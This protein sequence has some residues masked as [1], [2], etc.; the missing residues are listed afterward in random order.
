MPGEADRRLAR[1]AAVALLDA[2]ASLRQHP[3]NTSLH[4]AVLR[5]AYAALQAA[6]IHAPLVLGLLPT[7]DDDDDGDDDAHATGNRVRLAGDRLR[8][9]TANGRRREP[10]FAPLRAAGV[11]ELV[12]LPGFTPQELLC[13]A[14]HLA[15]MS[16][17]DDPEQT[18]RRLQRDPGLGH[19]QLRAA[20][21]SARSAGG[22]EALDWTAL[23]TVATRSPELTAMVARDLA[24]NLPALVTRQILDDLATQPGAGERTLAQLLPRLLDRGDLA[25]ASWLLAEVTHDAPHLADGLR[26][27]AADRADDRWL[28]QLLTQG[29][30]D[31]LMQ[32]CT[33]V[34]QLPDEVP[35]RF[36]ALLASTSHPLARWLRDL[37]G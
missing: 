22:D 36:A 13:L 1:G 11:G 35:M 5:K 29:T 14:R 37:L 2:I 16:A 33:F 26:R 10:P 25:T 21:T 28:T 27:I 3:G 8:A 31:E 19:V 17:D 18:V 32:L 23:P 20:A 30:R 6:T 7:P 12:L 34:M 15:A 24:G 4:H 9:S